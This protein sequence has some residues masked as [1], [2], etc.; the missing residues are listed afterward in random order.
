MKD[1]NAMMHDC[2]LQ[3][4]FSTFSLAVLLVV[5]MPSNAAAETLDQAWAAALAADHSLK[6][7][8]DN[9]AAV[10]RQLAAAK[11]AR[12]PS[13]EMDADYVALSELPTLK[14]DLLGQSF[15]IPLMQRNGAVYNA[16]ER[17]R[18]TRVDASS[19]A[20]PQPPL[21]FKQPGLARPLLSNT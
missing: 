10:G 7:S 11:T 6:A 21:H 5:Q 1:G 16:T 13:L 2:R 20:S 12:L 19:T 17:C 3:K 4:F 8:R 14:A 15:Q 9:S 18:F